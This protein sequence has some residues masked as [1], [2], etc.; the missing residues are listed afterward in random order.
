MELLEI[1]GEKR[2]KNFL[3]SAMWMCREKDEEITVEHVV[4]QLRRKGSGTAA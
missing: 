1:Q 2:K 3:L 4:E